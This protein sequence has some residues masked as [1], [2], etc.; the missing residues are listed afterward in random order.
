MP[1]RIKIP[2]YPITDQGKDSWTPDTGVFSPNV[3][4][5]QPTVVTRKSLAGTDQSWY[6]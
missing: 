1:P 6:I 2:I 5:D 3:S 4:V